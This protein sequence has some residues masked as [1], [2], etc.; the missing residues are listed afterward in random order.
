MHRFLISGGPGS[1]KSTLIQALQ[2]MHCC[3][4]EEASR[5]IIREEVAKH[6]N[7]LPW[8][9]L[10]CFASKVLDQMICDYKKTEKNKITFFDRGIPDIIAYLKVGNEEV[11]ESYALAMAQYPYASPVF[12]APPW[13]AIYV[14]DS[15]RWQ[16]YEEAVVLHGLIKETYLSQGYHIIELPKVSVQERIHFLLENISYFID[17]NDIHLY[18]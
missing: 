17:I 8:V 14:N 5:K 15:E 16:S 4:V 2:Q 3:C 10:S 9:N 7:C 12:L 13:E 6:S 11:A 18:K 1:G